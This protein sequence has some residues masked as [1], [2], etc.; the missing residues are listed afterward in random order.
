MRFRMQKVFLLLLTVVLSTCSFGVMSASAADVITKLV[1]NKN[2]VSLDVGSTANL[3]ATAIYD[4]GKTETVTV[5]TEWNSEDPNIASVYAGVITA[6]AEGDVIITAKYMTEQVPVKVKVTKRVKSLIKDKQKIDLRKGQ[7]EQVTLKA[8]YDDGSSED[9]T[10]KAEWT[11]DNGTIATLFNGK[12]TAQGSG[13]GTITAKFGNQSVSIPLT[14]EVVKRVDAD[15]SRVSLLLNQSETI[16]LLA[17]YP[18]GTT[19]DVT[20]SADWTSDNADV[21]DALKGKI[22]GYGPGQA[23][24]TATYGTKTAKI[25]VD[26]DNA[27]KLDLSKQNLLMKKSTTEQLKLTATYPNGN[28]EDITDRAEWSSSDDT[29]V[30][31]VKGKISANKTGEA[32]VTAKYGEKSVTAVVDVDVPRRLELSKDTITLNSGKSEQLTLDATY[33]DGSSEDVTSQAKWSS[34]KETIASVINGKVTA[35]KAGEATITAQYGEKTVTAKVLVDIPNVLVPSKKKVNFQIGDSEQITLKAVYPDGVNEDGLEKKAEWTSSNDQIAEVRGGM[36]TGLGTGT[37][38]ITAKFGNRSTTIQVSVGVLKT[39][40]ADATSLVLKKGDT[41]TIKLDAMYTDGKTNN[42]AQDAEWTSSNPAVASV[43][44]GTIK[45]LASGETT[46]TAK[47][48]TKTVTITVQVDMASTLKASPASIQMDLGETRTI[49]LTSTDANGK[50]EDVEGTAEWTSVSPTIAQVEKG[51][52]TALARGKTTITAKFGGK[53][54]TIPVDIGSVTDLVPNKRYIPMKT[55]GTFQVQLTATMADGTTKDVTSQAQWKSTN[56]KLLEVDNGLVKAIA[57]GSASIS[58]TFNGK[59]VAI[60]VDIDRLKYLKTDVV[61]LNMKSGETLNVRATA[62]FMDGSDEDV[63]V[64]GLWS[65]TNIRVADVK[66]GVIKATGKGRATIT[67]GYASK[68][69]TILVNV[70]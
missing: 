63:T 41:R 29:I 59:S 61:S 13:S 36:I 2:E 46:I 17:T 34:D 14:V 52:V 7:A 42:V 33:A 19:E 18:D 10:A 60:P 20:E 5:K 62:T 37:A 26:V 65:S 49:K 9:V 48:D 11:I 24:I 68:K 50:A 21:A 35:V 58:A 70:N 53:T 45:A 69:T 67:V 6:K 28:T 40:T 39:L 4:N 47:V 56:Y 44:E 27:I 55:E 64:S 25:K 43:S 30:Y 16:R 1:L 66:D 23:N 12:V 22:T 57:S 8:Y 38:T 51:V 54:V 15:K 31:V 3:T 32:T